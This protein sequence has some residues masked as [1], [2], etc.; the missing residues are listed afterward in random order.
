MFW[1]QYFSVIFLIIISESS[2]IKAQK[3]NQDCRKQNHDLEPFSNVFCWDSDIS[4]RSSGDKIGYFSQEESESKYASVPQPDQS[5][6][7]A[8]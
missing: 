5:I 1:F 4:R 3:L 8:S 6:S 2:R 7:T